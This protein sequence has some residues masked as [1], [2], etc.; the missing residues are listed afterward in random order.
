MYITKG[1]EQTQEVARAPFMSQAPLQGV[2]TFVFPQTLWRTTLNK[3]TQRN[4][5]IIIDAIF[6]TS[7]SCHECSKNSEDK[8][9]LNSFA[10]L[11]G[12][13]TPTPVL[14]TSAN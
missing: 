11:T 8:R 4:I 6:F 13:S 10:E 9:L 7:G 3:Y 2:L 1:Q 5:Q 12:F 14:G